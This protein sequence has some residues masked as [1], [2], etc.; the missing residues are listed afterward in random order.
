MNEKSDAS[1]L[2][3]SKEQEAQR[4]N[5]P[6]V[7]VQTRKVRLD[8]LIE[9][10]MDIVRRKAAEEKQR[11]LS[12]DVQ[13]CE[14][15]KAFLRAR[16]PEPAIQFVLF[17]GIASDN[18]VLITAVNFAISLAHDLSSKVLLIDGSVKQLDKTAATMQEI[19]KPALLLN[20][21]DIPWPAYAVLGKPNLYVLPTK[22]LGFSLPSSAFDVFLCKVREDFR[23]VVIVGSAIEDGSENLLLS[24]QVDG[25]ILVIESEATRKRAVRRVKARVE[26]A[27]AKLL[28]IVLNQRKYCS[29]DWLYKSE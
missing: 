17:I 8:S 6:P 10:A 2:T 7:V 1:A 23:H 11:G 21:C 25:V 15:L 27:G 28:G 5:F 4:A 29:P 16:Y 14:R 13:Q 3:I 18:G 9:T 26:E 12:T 24:Q 20:S 22:E 19:S